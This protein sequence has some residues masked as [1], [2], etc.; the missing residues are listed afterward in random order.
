MAAQRRYP[1]E[2]RERAVKMV[3]EIRQRDGKGNGE[4][5]RVGRQLDVHPE[6]AA[7]WAESTSASLAAASERISGSN[8][9]SATML[10]K[11]SAAWASSTS[12]NLAA[13]S[14]RSSCSSSYMKL[15][16]HTCLYRRE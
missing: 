14:K 9:S 8:A 15:T 3:L 1:E 12:A 13:A 7:A 16:L 5:A 6:G 4:I 11:A 10:R 2:L